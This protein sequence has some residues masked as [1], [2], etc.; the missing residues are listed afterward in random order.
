MTLKDGFI[1]RQVA[2]SWVVVA[3]GHAC[4]DFDGMLSLNDAGALLWRALE[5][6]G[7][8]EDLITALTDTYDVDPAQAGQDTDEFL[9]TIRQAG[10]LAE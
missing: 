8:R 3:T 6:G 5:Q 7:G 1:L 4:V 10:C 2:G 9:D